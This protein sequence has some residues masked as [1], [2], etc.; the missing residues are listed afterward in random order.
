MSKTYFNWSSGKDSSIAL[1]KALKDDN[2]RIEKLLTTINGPLQRVSMHG[3]HVD[4]LH[5]QAKSIGI[6]LDVLEVPKKPTMEDYND[7]MK[8][9]VTS[10]KT[11]GY[12]HTIFGDIFL[13]DLRDYRV[14]MLEPLGITA[15]FPIW[16][17][18]TLT[19][20]REFIQL[21]F[22]A[23]IVCI[24]NKLLD[25]SFLGKQLDESFIKD[26]PENVDPC[27][28]NGEFHTFCFDGP[29][30]S[31][32]IEFELGKKLFTHYDEVDDPKDNITF[33]FIDLVLK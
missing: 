17:I 4:L 1:Y 11:Q 32:P 7:L 20:L 21:G 29:I 8:T 15:H 24:N 19:L 30:F 13:E 3:L 31:E 10:L 9:K 27:G 22:K 16:K 6:P 23:V 25:E 33:G 2:F 5:A 14:K 12:D 18:D 26:L 28:E